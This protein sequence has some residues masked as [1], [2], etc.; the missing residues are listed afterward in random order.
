MEIVIP[1]APRFPQNKL[2]EGMTSHRFSV[3]V[4]HRR[5]GKTVCA[6]NQM[7]KMALESKKK[8]AR[9][10]YIAPLLKQAKRNTWDY[11][12]RYTR[13]I[14]GTKISESELTIDLLNGSRIML[15]GADNPD[16]IRGMYLD[17]VVMDEV[18][19]MK[20]EVWDEIVRPTLTDRSG[21]A[22]FIG[23]PK[24]MNLFYELYQKAQV[25]NGWYAALYRVDETKIV[26]EEE[27]EMLKNTMSDTA[28]RQEYLCDFSASSD[29]TLITID[30]VTEA[31]SRR[32]TKADVAGA[33]VIMG[34]DVARYG[35]DRSVIIVREGLMCYDPLVFDKVDNMTF[36]SRVAVQIQEHKPDAVFVDAG[37]GEG[38]IDR[39]R[40][41]G[42]VVIEVNFGGKA[43]DPNRYANKRTEM[44]DKCREWIE[45]GGYLPNIPDLKTDLIA[46]TY[47]ID[48]QN[49]MV[50]EPKDKIKERGGRS[51]DI[52]D[53]LA[54]TFAAPVYKKG[55]MAKN[56]APYFDRDKYFSNYDEYD[57]FRIS[58]Y[59]KREFGKSYQ[60]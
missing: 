35:D 32:L 50:L 59:E 55:A 29:N 16:A 41:L 43:I 27:L 23:T 14:P 18:A 30:M 5:M 39:L 12:K 24:G 44:W 10:A 8:D 45:A 48:A 13:P 25:S 42:F 54:L 20:P 56:R 49:R 21:W 40:Q 60:W 22:I 37:R 52:A 4:A 31:C 57:P 1:Y 28:F 6:V 11:F 46:P 53:A 58:K 19:Q 34:V 38:V 9:Y 2:H 47:R 7:I 15:L 51:P 3:I 36:A 33:P 26:S 17:G